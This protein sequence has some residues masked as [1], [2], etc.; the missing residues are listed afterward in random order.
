MQITHLHELGWNHFFQSQLTL[1]ALETELPFRVTGVQRNLI[2]CL[3]LDA[4]GQMQSVQLSTYPWRHEP[5]EN[6]PT[7]GDWLMLDRDLQP[8]YLLERKTLIKRRSA[9]SEAVLQLIAANIDTLFVVT[10]CNEEFNLNRIERYLVLAAEASIDAVVVLTKKDLCAD[11]SV[12]VDALRKDYPSLPVEV[13]NA[14]DARDVAVLEMWCPGGQTIALLGSSGVGKS[15]LL[16]SLKGDAGQA[17]APIREKDSKGRHTTTSRSL[18]RLRGGGILLDTPG[19]RELQ[20]VDCEEGIQSTFADIEQLAQQCR[21]HDCE[22][23][24]EPGCAV[25]LAVSEGRLEQRRLDNY[26]K[27]LAEQARNSGSVAERRQQD[28]ALGRFFKQA[29]ASAQ[30]FKSR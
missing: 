29:K 4:H 30:R 6:H 16:N 9:G 5:P 21:F 14:T 26:H 18:H 27:L 11:T 13:I 1:A 23:L 15:T 20:M 25:T 17:T 2:E 8:L 7:V 19:M 24:A 28:R 22:H 3:G 12:Y 10:S